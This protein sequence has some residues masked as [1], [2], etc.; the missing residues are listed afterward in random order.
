L[1]LDGL[2]KYLW[3]DGTDCIDAIDNLIEI[4]A[5]ILSLPAEEEEALSSANIEILNDPAGESERR[6][7]ID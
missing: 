2:D 1:K 6:D 5:L 3:M 7:N 4:Q